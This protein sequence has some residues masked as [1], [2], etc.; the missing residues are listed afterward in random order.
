MTPIGSALATGGVR[1]LA[2]ARASL[3][4]SLAPLPDAF[5]L[6]VLTAFDDGAD[7]ACFACASRGCWAL[8]ATADLWRGLTLATF[9][10]DWAWAGS[11]ARTYAVRRSGGRRSGSDDEPAPKR[12]RGAP[13]HPLTLQTHPHAPAAIAAASRPHPHLS[14]ALPSDDAFAPWA[15]A[16]LDA[17]AEGWLKRDTLPRADAASLTVSD[18]EARY[19]VPGTPVV[20]AGG[21]AADSPCFTRWSDDALASRLTTVHAGGVDLLWSTYAAYAATTSDDTPLTVFDSAVLASAG[22]ADEAPRPRCTPRDLF[23]VLPPASRPDASWLI[24]GPAGSGSTMVSS[25]LCGWKRGNVGGVFPPPRPPTITLPTL[26][27]H[28]AR[29]PERHLRLQWRRARRQEVG[30]VP[31][32]PPAPGDP[33]L[34]RRRPRRRPRHSA[35]M[36]CLVL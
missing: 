17:Q 33:P 26:S 14:Y 24:V 23:G 19:D 21:L 18:F 7:V 28:T 31:A 30:P 5:L 35:R 2:S 10:G 8:A 32:R 3:G 27:T 29:R 9:G 20:L 12:R 11:W 25:V 16:A 4:P 1:A 6:A 22:L 13:H 34:A 15:V 36:V